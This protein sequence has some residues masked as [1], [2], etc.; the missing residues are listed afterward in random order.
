MVLEKRPFRE[1]LLALII[2]ILE[3][4]LVGFTYSIKQ[5]IKNSKI[6]MF[7]NKFSVT[8]CF[9]IQIRNSAVHA[10]EHHTNLCHYKPDQRAR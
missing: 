6:D 5:L 10:T 7:T 1:V 2:E 8:I 9:D 4:F 3:L